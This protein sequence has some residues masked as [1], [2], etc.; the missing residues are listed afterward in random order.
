[1]KKL[2]AEGRMT[3]AGRQAFAHRRED[4]SA[5]YSY[6]QRASAALDAADAARFR[7]SKAAWKFFQAQ[8]P[9]YRQQH[10]YRVVS[11][12]REE[13]RQARLDKLIA[14]S[15]RGERLP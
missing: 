4:R 14:A 9:G 11:A 3:E 13:T 15:E 5:I 6:E 10:V 12:K 7:A 2:E 8:P 1:M